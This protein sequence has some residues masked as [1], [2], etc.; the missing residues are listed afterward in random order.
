MIN[1]RVSDLDGV[2]EKLRAADIAIVTNSDW[3]HPDV[4]RFARIHDAEGNAIELWELAGGGRTRA[5]TNGEAASNGLPDG[6][7]SKDEG[8]A[9]ICAR[10]PF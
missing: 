6:S 4:G 8:Y 5:G 9:P 1:L 10:S 3:D 7:A 2:L